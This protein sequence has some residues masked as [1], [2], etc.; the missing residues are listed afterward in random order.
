MHSIA[1]SLLLAIVLLASSCHAPSARV[2]SQTYAADATPTPVPV[3]IDENSPFFLR[4]DEIAKTQCNLPTI[5][6][7]KDM[8]KNHNDASEGVFP[9][10]YEYIVKH[11]AKGTVIY[12]PGGPG[13]DSIGL[14]QADKELRDF[15][16][17]Y[18]DPRDTGCNF[19]A[20]DTFKLKHITTDEHA[21][22]IIRVIQ[23]LRLSNYIIY[24]GSYGTVVA[25]VVAAEA[26]RLGLHPR[27]VVLQ[28]VVAKAF[29]HG[30][31]QT[32]AEEINALMASSPLLVDFFK[33]TQPILGYSIDQW[34]ALS[35]GLIVYSRSFLKDVFESARQ[36]EQ[37]PSSPE[38]DQFK[39]DISGMMASLTEKEHLGKSSFYFAVACREI[40]EGDFLESPVLRDGKLTRIPAVDQQALKLCADLGPK[41][42]YDA[43]RYQIRAPL[44]YIQGGNDPST[45][46]NYAKFHY[47][48]QKSS[49]QKIWLGVANGGH[50]PM[51]AFDQLEPCA[52]QL[53]ERIMN[54]QA[55]KGVVDGEGHCIAAPNDQFDPNQIGQMNLTGEER[56][57]DQFHFSPTDF[58]R[59]RQ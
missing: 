25:M 51:M 21:K 49:T 30:I 20:E 53:W 24:G 58:R 19:V 13:G 6:T 17:I 5:R 52:P 10:K 2:S 39:K 26:E 47:A 14:A 32:T 45:P 1:K 35:M 55:F 4:A 54:L 23:D 59:F 12:I 11:Q 28:G 36:F 33:S 42:F 40:A 44:Y 22:D 56:P 15:N 57:K 3:S 31:K 38:K 50:G 29:T 46:I 43:D 9:Y 8:P 48:G 27:A 37:A 41:K 34:A 7:I 16:I 18:I